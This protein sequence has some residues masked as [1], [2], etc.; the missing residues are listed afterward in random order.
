MSEVKK[1]DI[2]RLVYYAKVNEVSNSLNGTRINCNDLERGLAFSV[3]GD[4]LAK[5]L[6]SADQFQSTKKVT[7]TDL[8]EI[9]SNVRENVFTVEFDK[10][11]GETR[12][13]RGYLVKKET[14]LGRSVVIDLDLVDDQKYP[15]H[16]S[17]LRQVDHRTIQSLIVDGV[18]YVLK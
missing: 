9:F 10:Q 8:V 5:T 4:S 17:R 16:D 1:G 15:N 13:L 6:T 12:K 14:G 7:K 3:V 18:K 11:N 2:V